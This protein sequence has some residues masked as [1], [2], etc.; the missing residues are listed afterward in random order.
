M[1]RQAIRRRLRWLLGAGMPE[2]ARDLIVQPLGSDV[3][4]RVVFS[5]PPSDVAGDT[6]VSYAS[7]GH[8]IFSNASNHRMDPL[9]TCSFPK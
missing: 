9:V 5:A 1:R 2:A 7:R 8:Y 6:E 3:N 4:G